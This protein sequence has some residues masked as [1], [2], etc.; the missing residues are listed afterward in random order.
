M[1]LRLF[2]GDLTR[3]MPI[4]WGQ[5]LVFSMEDYH[6]VGGKAMEDH[7]VGVDACCHQSKATMQ[8]DTDGCYALGECALRG[9]AAFRCVRRLSA[10][11]GEP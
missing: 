1:L 5:R 3:G 4:L 10:S 6:T 7:T 11:R 9:R 8:C 2:I